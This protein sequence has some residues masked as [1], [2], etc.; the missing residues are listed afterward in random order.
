MLS[1]NILPRSL[2]RDPKQVTRHKGPDGKGT[3]AYRRKVESIRRHGFLQLPGILTDGTVLWG[4]GRILAWV[5]ARPGEPVPVAILDTPM[6]EG[7]YGTAD[8]EQLQERH[9]AAAQMQ[10]IADAHDRRGVTARE[11]ETFGDAFGGGVAGL[12]QRG[13]LVPCLKRRCGRC[14]AVCQVVLCLRLLRL[15]R[16]LR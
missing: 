16:L 3:E 10:R 6:P 5:E 14:G 7:E 8:D 2:K 12:V 4:T 13:S 15:L 9:G 11:A 1:K